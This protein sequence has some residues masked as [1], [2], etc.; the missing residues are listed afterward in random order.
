V[1]TRAPG[2]VGQLWPI[3]TGRIFESLENELVTV[4]HVGD[5]ADLSSYQLLFAL[6]KAMMGTRLLFATL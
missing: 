3:I 6:A 1:P 2:P 4:G 5:P